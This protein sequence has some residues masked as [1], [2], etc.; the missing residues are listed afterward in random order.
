MRW[1]ASSL[2]LGVAGAGVLVLGSN[3][4]LMWALNA[5]LLASVLV[6]VAGAQL[7]SRPSGPRL[8][9][10]SIYFP[11]LVLALVAAWLGLQASGVGGLVGGHPAWNIAGQA[12]GQ[13]VIPSISVNPNET[14][15]SLL[16]WLTAGAAFAAA[17]CLARERTQAAYLLNGI[18]I[19]IGVNA[20]YGLI[21]LL[22]SIDKIL[23]FEHRQLGV[24]SGGF[25]NANS[26]SMHIGLGLIVAF[27]LLLYYFRDVAAGAQHQSV[28]RKIGI[29]L[30]G[31]GGQLGVYGVAVITLALCLLLTGSRAGVLF[32]VA[33]CAICLLLSTARR[34][35]TMGISGGAWAFL[36]LCIFVA[37]LVVMELAG[38]RLASQLATDGLKN[39]SRLEVTGQSLIAIGDYF[40]LG[41]GG[42]TFQDVFPMYRIENSRGGTVWD[43][44]HNDY[45]E[46]FLGLGVIAGAA[47]ISAFG[48]VLA[49]CTMGIFNRRRD[50]VYP[51]AAVSTSVLVGLHSMVDFGIQMQANALAYAIVLGVGLAQSMSSRQ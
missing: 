12:L 32:T 11:L 9:F 43:K 42:G 2:L 37:G 8:H 16:K 34:G 20:A 23:W 7:N 21:R 26:A 50:H 14:M 33:G 47:V 10:S 5:L 27:S 39:S 45:A 1:L 38:I 4:P 22:F 49:K 30:E 6:L 18:L 15:W 19:V 41:S 17:Y 29:G 48:W 36:C 25:V 28:K 31:L 24:L 46:L 40:L 51:I 44:A 35:R 13:S 3:R